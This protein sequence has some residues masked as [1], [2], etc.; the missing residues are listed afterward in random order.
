VERQKLPH[1]PRVTIK[2]VVELRRSL[3][4]GKKI[5]MPS[6]GEV[7]V[8]K[9]YSYLVAVR[10]SRVAGMNLETMPYTQIAIEKLGLKWD[11]S[12]DGKE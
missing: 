10:H 2:D 12:P 3:K 9:K 5:I 4:V 8:V 1:K 11:R 6:Y 7:I